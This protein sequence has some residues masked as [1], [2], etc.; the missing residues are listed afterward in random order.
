VEPDNAASTDIVE[1]ALT[2]IQ[3]KVKERRASGGLPAGLEDELDR[4]YRQVSDTMHGTSPALR[5][6]S[7][8]LRIIGSREFG[9]EPTEYTSSIPLG[10]V[11][12]RAMDKVTARQNLVM[13]RQ[14]QELWE[15]TREALTACLDA[16]RENAEH[17]HPQLERRLAFAIDKL[18]AFDMVRDEIAS[19]GARVA[20]LEAK[21][22]ISTD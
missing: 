1:A 13:R 18:A 19:L 3:N 12:H 7:A 6:A 16:I 9:I 4:H 17:A 5:R 14:M 21:F 8:A 22:S 2:R 15:V 20:E 10:A 11:V